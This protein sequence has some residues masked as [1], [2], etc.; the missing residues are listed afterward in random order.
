MTKPN[1]P[2]HWTETYWAGPVQAPVLLDWEW[3]DDISTA[4][5][6]DPQKVCDYFIAQAARWKKCEGLSEQARNEL[7]C[8]HASHAMAGL[9]WL[10][11]QELGAS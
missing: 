10:L 5:E 7:I 2:T 1:R 4:C 9:Y 6:S 3:I 8:Y 11:V